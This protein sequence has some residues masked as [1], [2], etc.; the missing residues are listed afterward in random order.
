MKFLYPILFFL[1]MCLFP[2]FASGQNNPTGDAP[3]SGKVKQEAAKENL[4]YRKQKKIHEKEVKAHHKRVQTKKIRK[5]MKKD[6]RKAAL[7]NDR[8]QEFFLIRWFSKKK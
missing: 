6:K 4:S 8:K 2:L 1:W 7:N 3:T 5:Q